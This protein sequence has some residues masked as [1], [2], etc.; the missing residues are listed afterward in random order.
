MQRAQSALL[1]WPIVDEVQPSADVQVIVY[2][3]VHSCGAGG[4]ETQC[5]LD[6]TGVASPQPQVTPPKDMISSAI[7]NT[8][9]GQL[10][11]GIEKT[12]KSILHGSSMFT[13]PVAVVM[14][15]LAEV[16]ETSYVQA[17][18]A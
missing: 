11:V 12:V 8:L 2:S 16:H 4:V 7:G 3:P 13:L 1:N 10:S 18:P 9:P 5:I 14:H 15:P 17:V 6:I